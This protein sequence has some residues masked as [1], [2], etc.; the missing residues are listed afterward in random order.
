VFTFVCPDTGQ[1]TSDGGFTA[2]G[3]V[4][5]DCTIEIVVTVEC[6]VCGNEHTVL[7]SSFPELLETPSTST[8]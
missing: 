1:T 5:V 2:H 6:R 7:V 3:N 4:T 8:T